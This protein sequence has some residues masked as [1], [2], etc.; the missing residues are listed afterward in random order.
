[1]RDSSVDCD[2]ASSFAS[3]RT[4]CKSNRLFCPRV[5]RSLKVW[6]GF[7]L[8]NNVVDYDNPVIGSVLVNS[9]A[10]REEKLSGEE[11]AKLYA[12]L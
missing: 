10:N 5:T 1:M 7:K 6:L 8:D 4:A 2:L 12:A 9:M 11:K 3:C